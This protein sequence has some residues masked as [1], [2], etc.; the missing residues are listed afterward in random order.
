MDHLDYVEIADKIRAKL[1]NKIDISAHI[2]PISKDQN[3]RYR[4]ADSQEELIMSLFK[5]NWNPDCFTRPSNSTENG[6]CGDI[7]ITKGKDGRAVLGIDV[8]FPSNEMRS[9]NFF[10]PPDFAS[11]LYLTS[12]NPPSKVNPKHFPK[13]RLIMTF[14]QQGEFKFLDPNEVLQALLSG[15]AELKASY[16][17]GRAKYP[18]DVLDEVVS[19]TDKIK[20][21]GGDGELW[22]QDFLYFKSQKD[23]MF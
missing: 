5:A 3:E 20:V 22:P 6:Y 12:Q 23:L 19:Y 15:K 4:N 16:H 8:K 11:I 10:S 17:R 7:I 18:K 9:G 1:G 14:N 13:N 2:K 21:L